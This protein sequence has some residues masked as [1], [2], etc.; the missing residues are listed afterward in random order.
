MSLKAGAKRTAARPPFLVWCGER[1]TASGKVESLLL[2]FSFPTR[3]RGGGNVEI[4]SAISKGCGQR[5][6]PAFGFPRCPSDRHFHGPP[7]S[8]TPPLVKSCEQLPFRCLHRLGRR[9]V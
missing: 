1:K 3:R 2:L 4:A 6:K 5:G 7:I 9:S 8:S